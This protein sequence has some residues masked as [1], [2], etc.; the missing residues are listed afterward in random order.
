MNIIK[1]ILIANRGEI[2]VRVMKTAKKLGIKTVAVYSEIDKDSLHVSYA[3]DAHCIGESELSDTYLNIEKIIGI[4]KK[5]NCDAIHPGYGFMAENSQFVNACNDS[6]IIFIGPNTNSMKVM[7]NKIE[8]REFV[9]KLNIP[10]TEGVTGNIKSLLE[11]SKNIPFPLLLKAA[12]GGGGKGMRIVYKQEELAEAIEATSREAKSYF[13]DETVYIEKYIQNPRH[14]EVQIL[15]DNFGNVIHLFERECSVQRR[16]QKIIEESPSPTLTPELRIK[17][18]EAAVRIGK[19]INYN[20]AGTIEF[21]V[22]ENLNFYFLEMNTRIQVEH[23][24]T[25]MVTGIDIVEEQIHIA[26]GNQLRFKQEDIKQTGHSIEC[27]IYAEDPL[28]NFQPSP[29][30]MLLFKE[31]EISNIRID[32]GITKD[33]EIK[34]SF[35]PMICKLIVFSNTREEAIEKMQNALYEFVIHGI[36]TNISYLIA[37]LKNETFIKNKISTKFCDEFTPQILDN[38]NNEK[39]NIPI[40]IP[41]IA[42][43][44]FSLNNKSVQERIH[45]KNIWNTIG[46][47]RDL[48]NIRIVLSEKEYVVGIESIKNNEYHIDLSGVK[49][50]VVFKSIKNKKIELFINDILFTAYISE[51]LKCNASLSYSGFIFN[52]NRKDILHKDTATFRIE[53]YIETTNN[54]NSPMPGKVI[55]INVNEGDNVKKG[56][57]L[58]IIEAMKME[59]RICCTKESAIIESVNVKISQ[60]VDTTTALLT[61]KD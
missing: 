12:A 46:Y 20:N 28:N 23:P 11:A 47:W 53:D 33:T 34:S 8:A 37:L 44:L 41:V 43:S 35:D 3:D 52:L 9:K 10:M 27:R 40:F 49:Y 61:F 15:G 38:L 55:K 26:A 60:M 18:G 2:A 16:Y 32:T 56:D 58:M 13:G 45:Y 30:K 7:G 50:L 39:Q 48:M 59:N 1:K 21:L 57:I 54:V 17:M 24:V 29:G 22:D 14:I 36:K 25:E 51:D 19:E 6:G 31:P 4:A 5:T 42:Y